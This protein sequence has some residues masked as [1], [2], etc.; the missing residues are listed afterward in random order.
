LIH[1]VVFR[2][3]KFCVEIRERQG[4][5][6][7]VSPCEVV[8]HPGAVVILP[9]VDAERICM[10]RNLRASVGETLWELPAGTL[11]PSESPENCA[12][13]ELA[14]ETGYR[15]ACLRKLAEYY[16]S[17]GVLDERMHL[18]VAE[19]LTLGERQPES[20]ERIEPRVVAWRQA[21]EWTTDGTIRDGKTLVGILLWERLR[22]GGTGR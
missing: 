7:T 17:P 5:D 3:K 11:E 21:L 8:V 1:R 14:E 19:Q 4:A 20:D 9:F 13:R 22:C 16:P 18:F 15:A 10:I 12:Q 6:G 2:C